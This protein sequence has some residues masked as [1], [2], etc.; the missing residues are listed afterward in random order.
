MVGGGL[1]FGGPGVLGLVFGCPGVA[2]G[3]LVL[4]GP[5]VL[6][7]GGPGVLVGGLLPVGV[8]GGGPGV[9]H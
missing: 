8:P 3:G 1:V 7:V 6:T 2:G 5:G 9:E 4:G